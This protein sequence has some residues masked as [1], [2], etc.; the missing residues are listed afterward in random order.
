MNFESWLEQTQPRRDTI[1]AF[2]KAV[3]LDVDTAI[4]YSGQIGMMENQ[5]D[6]FAKT[7]FARCIRE[8]KTRW[9]EHA[10]KEREIF[11]RAEL[12]PM[13]QFVA[14]LSIIGRVIRDR[15]YN[16]NASR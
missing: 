12:A 3:I 13:F 7:E 6:A 5:A 2:S 4:D 11:V 15:L 9:P 8:A 1:T 10:A 16:R 14:D